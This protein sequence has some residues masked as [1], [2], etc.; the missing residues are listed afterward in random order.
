MKITLRKDIPTGFLYLINPKY[1][2]MQPLKKKRT[3]KK[4]LH[5][6]LKGFIKG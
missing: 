6:V 1:L 5:G 2:K 3:T 4:Q